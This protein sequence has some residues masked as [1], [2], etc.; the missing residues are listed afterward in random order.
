MV[1]IIRLTWVEVRMACILGIE[2][3]IQSRQQNRNTD[4]AAARNTDN[5]AIDIDGALA[6]MALAKY[7]GVFFNPT[8][9]TF[10]E[11]DVKRY[12]V[13]STSYANGH[14]IIR[15]DDKPREL[16]D[17]EFVL[18]I[19]TFMPDIHLVGMLTAGEAAVDQYWRDDSWWVPN[20]HLGPLPERESR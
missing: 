14:L 18:G 7:L 3:R 9:N 12:Q 13:R 20:G 2:R 11:P 15:P 19:T 10:K 1:E 6:E 17:Q 8:I 5:W 16:P 4:K